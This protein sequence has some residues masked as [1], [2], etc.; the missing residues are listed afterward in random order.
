[1]IVLNDIYIAP[2]VKGQKYGMYYSIKTGDDMIEYRNR[3]TMRT[4]VPQAIL[5]QDKVGLDATATPDDVK[6][7][8]DELL[9]AEGRLNDLYKIASDYYTVGH[10]D[11]DISRWMEEMSNVDANFE[12]WTDNNVE[13]K[14]EKE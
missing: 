9:L 10:S 7:R 13:Q 4:A 6:V 8:I 12:E 5:I 14:G 2:P 1:M 3:D 11:E